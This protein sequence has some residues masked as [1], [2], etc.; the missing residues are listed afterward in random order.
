[1]IGVLLA[2]VLSTGGRALNSQPGAPGQ[3]E[4][5]AHE[6]IHPL[7]GPVYV[8]GSFGEYRKFSRYHHGLD[9]K[10]F[11]RNGLTV[12]TPLAGVVERVHVSET[13]YGN[14][15]FLVSA[16]QIRTTYGHLNDFICPGSTGAQ[17]EDLRSAIKFLTYRR[18]VFI[19]IPGWFRFGAGDCIARSG[20][21]GTGAPHLHFEVQQN[22]R[23]IDPL[24][25]RGLRIPDDTAPTMLN[26]YVEDQGGLQRLPLVLGETGRAES[27]EALPAPEKSGPA[28][29]AD[30]SRQKTNASA[31]PVVAMYTLQAGAQL[32]RAP[33]SRVRYLIGAYDTMAARNRNGVRSLRLEVGGR[34]RFR[35]EL[36]EIQYRD[37]AQSA[38]VYQT[39]RTVI[40]RE[41]VY[42]LYDGK[43]DPN[44]SYQPGE[45]VR[46]TL[47][48]ASGNQAILEARLPFQNSTADHAGAVQPGVAMRTI[49]A[50]QTTQFS[51]TTARGGIKISFGP[52]SLQEDGSAR[53]FSLNALKGPAAESVRLP[54]ASTESNA[55]RATEAQGDE[56]STGSPVYELDGPV[57]R[58]EGRDLFYR[59][60]AQAE[61]WFALPDADGTADVGA[62]D[63][64][65][66][67]DEKPRGRL[68]LY[69]FNET[70][71]RWL[72]VAYPYREQDGRAFYRFPFR[73]EGA[74]AQLKD[75]SPPR[76]LQPS[77]WAPPTLYNETKNEI[78]REYMVVDEGS[79]FS[80]ED[81]EVYLD[82][83]PVPYE[84]I[85]DRAALQIRLPV[86]LVSARGAVISIRAADHGGNRSDWL[87]DFLEAPRANK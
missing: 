68:A 53:L 43:N 37:L 61:A 45:P 12:R 86:G 64:S 27:I 32:E 9:Y 26:L 30:E 4:L 80:K 85:P 31:P 84:W 29:A 41:Y 63:R 70:V 49:P 25:L 59:D 16:D 24:A 55:P 28:N 11:N 7:E 38:R 67:T 21:S 78:V 5:A 44:Q 35:Q 39:A 46:I 15:L 19:N 77:L 79:G 62:G 54:A 75:L 10:T 73:Y 20:E 14:G 2:V 52:R 83:R 22:G 17:L 76:I 36:G 33:G 57:F 69:S 40:G 74:L 1:M 48:D 82:G 58:F 65:K 51:T 66:T 56:R 50:G 23:Y 3:P 18:G 42:L 81:S 60:G 34:E 72:L 6:F 47:A 8:S 87:F 13:G 71:G